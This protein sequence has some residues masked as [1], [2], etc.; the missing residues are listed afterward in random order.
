MYL[1]LPV[2]KLRSSSTG[3]VHKSH[4]C[5]ARLKGNICYGSESGEP[6]FCLGCDSHMTEAT[7]DQEVLHRWCCCWREALTNLQPSAASLAAVHG[8]Q[9]TAGTP[10]LF[11]EPLLRGGITKKSLWFLWLPSGSL[12]CFYAYI[13]SWPQDFLKLIINFIIIN[14]HLCDQNIKCVFFIHSTWDTV[15]WNKYNPHTQNMFFFMKSKNLS[16]SDRFPVIV[17]PVCS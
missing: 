6:L 9:P 10:A 4:A 1:L 15:L 5:F 16:C 13:L 14:S 11:R 17:P 2:W 8:D 7:F 3:T 12:D